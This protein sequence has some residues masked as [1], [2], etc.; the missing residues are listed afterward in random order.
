MLD[1][2]NTLMCNHMLSLTKTGP[3]VRAWP[4]QLH[5]HDLEAYNRWV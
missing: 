1:M 3:I 4:N 5:I 2:V